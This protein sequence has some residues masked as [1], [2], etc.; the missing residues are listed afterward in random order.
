MT[1]RNGT[2][3]KG[4]PTPAAAIQ[5]R[6]S[7]CTAVCLS[8]RP[9]R[10]TKYTQQKKSPKNTHLAWCS[11]Q[12]PS[13]Q[14]VR[15][16]GWVECCPAERGRALAYRIA[17]HHACKD[18]SI[19]KSN[20]R[21]KYGGQLYTRPKLSVRGNGCSVNNAL[22]WTRQQATLRQRRNMRRS[23]SKSKDRHPRMNAQR[24][25]CFSPSLCLS[26]PLFV[27]VCVC[28]CLTGIICSHAKTY[29]PPPLK[30]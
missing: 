2:H 24:C 20:E 7:N 25:L 10:Y 12:C 3:T 23:K 17:P 16:R 28:V 11:S 21:R 18:G 19:R 8:V 14:A 27:C 22:M 6:C 26:L 9:K 30:K 5:N 29:Q 13:P 1:P 4:I 15:G